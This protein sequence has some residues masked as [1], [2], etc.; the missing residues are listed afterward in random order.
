MECTLSGNNKQAKYM[1]SQICKAKIPH[2]K[3]NKNTKNLQA[4]YIFGFRSKTTSMWKNIIFWYCLKHLMFQHLTFILFFPGI[5][6]CQKSIQSWK[7]PTWSKSSALRCPSLL[8]TIAFSLHYKPTFSEEPPTVV[9][10]QATN[11]V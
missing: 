4:E 2:S 5:R 10:G 8:Y 3:M 7:L 6:R 9:W 11:L 1:M